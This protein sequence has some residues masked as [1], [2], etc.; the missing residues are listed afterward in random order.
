MIG[1]TT[2]YT[3]RCK[4]LH[5]EA[6]RRDHFSFMNKSFN[7]QCNL[8][9]KIV[10]LL[11]MN[12]IIDATYFIPR[13]YTNFCTFLCELCDVGYYVINCCIH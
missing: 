6:E 5:C 9:K 3:M 7:M 4:D 2:V 10:F 8:T 11:L 12:I 13:I 1:M